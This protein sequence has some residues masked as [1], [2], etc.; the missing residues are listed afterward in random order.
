MKTF[1]K[2]VFA[3]LGVGISLAIAVAI[4][5]NN[6]EA[7]GYISSELQVGSRGADVTTLQTFLAGMPSIYPQGLIT[8]YFG[9]LTRSAV[10][11]FQATYGIPTVGRVGPMTLAKINSMLSAG[12]TG[13]M[14]GDMSA[15]LITGVSVSSS[16]NSSTIYWTTNESARTKV[17]YDTKP[18]VMLETSSQFAE[19]V[20]LNGMVMTDTSYR[21]STN[22]MLSNLQASSTYY[23]V[24]EAIDM[25]GNVSVSPQY[26]LTTNR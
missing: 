12:S 8:G 13:G 11:R 20:V 26:V 15:P 9:T 6:A 16:N 5:P 19:P 24:I 17:F 14:S 21:N 7:A 22:T 18:V 4:T 1:N 2:K 3:M 25:A 23:F 10:M